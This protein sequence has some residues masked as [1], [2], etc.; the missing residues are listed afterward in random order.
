M[1]NRSGDGERGLI[2]LTRLVPVVGGVVGGV[3]DAAACRMVAG[4]AC[5]VFASACRLERAGIAA[6]I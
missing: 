6:A 1:G 2:N 3:V 4:A 5:E